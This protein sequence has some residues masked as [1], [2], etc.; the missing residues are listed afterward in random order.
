MFKTMF[1]G[2]AVIALLT[3]AAAMNN[4]ADTQILMKQLTS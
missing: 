2:A 4:T 3:G 1:A